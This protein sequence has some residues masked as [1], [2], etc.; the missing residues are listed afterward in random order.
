M[1]EAQEALHDG[2]RRTAV[3]LGRAE[4]P[5]ALCGGY[6]LWARGAPEPDHDADFVIREQDVEPAMTAVAAAGLEVHEPAEDW[7]FKAFHDG[8]LVDVLFRLCGEQVEDEVFERAEVMEVLAVRMP[9]LAATDVFSTQLRV[10]NE[11][12]CD[13]GRLL[14]IARALREQID[15]EWVRRESAGTPFGRAFLHLVDGL[16][17]VDLGLDPAARSSGGASA[18]S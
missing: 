15:W 16:G 11:H 9:V 18:S 13:F 10:M 7:L 8:A 6:A 1:S 14:P 2:L 3:A 5:Y 17:I 4:I 12:Y